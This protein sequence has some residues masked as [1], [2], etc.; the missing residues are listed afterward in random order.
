MKIKHTEVSFQI[1]SPA[2]FINWNENSIAFGAIWPPLFFDLLKNKTRVLVPVL[3][4]FSGGWPHSPRKL[5]WDRKCV[6]SECQVSWGGPL[7][8]PRRLCGLEH[9]QWVWHR[10]GAQQSWR[11]S[12]Y[13]L[14]SFWKAALS[15]CPHTGL[16]QFHVAMTKCLRPSTSRG[17]WGWCC[18]SD[19][20]TSANACLMTLHFGLL[21]SRT[22]L[23]ESE[24]QR[25]P[26]PRS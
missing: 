25:W 1:G 15:R 13:F 21:H 26:L 3:G 16:C 2:D 23:M 18:L 12:L 17:T 19:P 20:G 5:A 14:A 6:T 22:F 4:A 7:L 10:T 9:T 8:W 24:Q 11:S